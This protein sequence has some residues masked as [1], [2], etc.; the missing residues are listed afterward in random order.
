M[1]NELDPDLEPTFFPAWV[2]LKKPALAK[3]PFTMDCAGAGNTSLQ[4]IYCLMGSKETGLNETHIKLRAGLQQ[5]NT[6]LFI[7]YMAA[8]S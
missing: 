2:V 6:E 7:H 3:H 4:S 5:Q 8:Y 1:A